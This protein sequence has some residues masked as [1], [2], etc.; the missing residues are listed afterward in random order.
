MCD[1]KLTLEGR[2]VHV[3][4]ISLQQRKLKCQPAEI[5]CFLLSAAHISSSIEIQNR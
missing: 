5:I 3:L 1:I 4:T 2:W